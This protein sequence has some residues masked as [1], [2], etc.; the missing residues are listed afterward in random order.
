[1]NNNQ[2]EKTPKY[3]IKVNGTKYDVHDHHLTFQQVVALASDLPRGENITYS[4]TYQFAD[5]KP[6][7]GVLAEG[8][9][10]KVQEGTK[11]DVTASDKS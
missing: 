3:T 9:K 11:F 8:G 4:I 10:V 1:M 6:E 7:S 5:Q 2:D